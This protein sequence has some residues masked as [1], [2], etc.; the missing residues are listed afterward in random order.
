MRRRTLLAAAAALSVLRIAAAWPQDDK[1]YEAKLQ[2]QAKAL[3]AIRA[4]IVAAAGYDEANVEV[5]PAPHRLVVRLVNS[6]R[7]ESNNA[8]LIEEANL[9]SSA[10]AQEIATRPDFNEIEMLHVDYIM[11]DPDGRAV[12]TVQAVDFRR[13]SEGKFRHQAS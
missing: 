10:V 11:R 12:A 2:R 13:D 8:A 5:T 6:K 7:A 1:E 9:I 4:A 3:P